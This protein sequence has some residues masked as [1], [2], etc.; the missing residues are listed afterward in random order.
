[1]EGDDFEVES[2]IATSVALVINELLQNSLKYAF[3]NRESGAVR[4]TVSKGTLYSRIKISDN[5]CGFDVKDI[6]QE[7]LG[8]KIVRSL[9][10]DKLNGNLKIESNKQ[11]TIVTFD[12]LNKTID[13][14]GA[15]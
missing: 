7:G 6:K 9:V 4:I 8:L 14:A 15:T 2:D 10:E 3:T 13:I 1:M 5:G 12:F 11:G